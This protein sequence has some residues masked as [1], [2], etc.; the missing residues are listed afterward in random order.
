MNA[1]LLRPRRVQ[2][3][4][5]VP[6]HPD[7]RDRI[8]GPP[9]GKVPHRVDLRD[10]RALDFAIY[11]QLQLGACTANAIAAAVIYAERREGKADPTPDTMPSRLAL[12]WWERYLEGSVDQDAGAAL[13]DGLKVVNRVGYI[14]E[15]RWPYDVSQFRV[16]PPD[17]GP[18]PEHVV[19][20]A[21]VPQT[22][23]GILGCLAKGFPFV[24]GFS[25]Y[26]SFPFDGTP[27][28][29]M[30]QP[31]EATEGGHAVLFTGYDLGRRGMELD[32]RGSW[33]DQW[34]RAGY[35]R[36]PLDYLLDRGLASDFWQINLET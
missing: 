31:D 15:A 3:L 8:F 22:R 25:V 16:R 30:P 11:D 19:R 18:R 27:D 13:R 10:T 9:A 28:V 35:G 29:P 32:W 2:G 33:S 34:G 5:W 20:Y 6:D 23:Q 24:G 17:F 21:R 4:G 26:E 12:Y 1:E 14:D 36:M 7:R